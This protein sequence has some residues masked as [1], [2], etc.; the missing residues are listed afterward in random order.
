MVSFTS[1][2]SL[3][4]SLK[5]PERETDTLYEPKEHLFHPLSFKGLFRLEEPR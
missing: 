4:L 3:A 5:M 1:K 2:Q